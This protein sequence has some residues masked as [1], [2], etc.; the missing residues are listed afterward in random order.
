M[1]VLIFLIGTLIGVVLGGAICVR[2]LRQEVAARIGPKMDLLQMQLETVQSAVNLALANWHAE[3]HQHG[4][5][6]Y[7]RDEF[8]SERRLSDRDF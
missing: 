6:P 2:Y 1:S 5:M 8:E 4:T 7:R 3:L